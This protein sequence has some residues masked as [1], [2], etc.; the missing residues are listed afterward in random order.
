M[1]Y[2]I[3][4]QDFSWTQK[5][6]WMAPSGDLSTPVHFDTVTK[7]TAA[8]LN[9]VEG[10]D[11]CIQAGGN[12]GLWPCRYAKEF[13]Q[14]LT[15]EP[16][17]ENLHCL[18]HN[19]EHLGNVIVFGDAL[20]DVCGPVEVKHIERKPV[21]YGARYVEPSEH[22]D[23][24]QIRLDD[25]IIEGDVDFIHLDIE[26]RELF[27]LQGMEGTISNHEPVIALEHHTLDQMAVPVDAAAN[28]LLER[29]YEIAE[30]FKFEWVFKPI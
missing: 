7:E 19:V 17:A 3:H 10:H 1:S 9:Y 16:C 2:E 6:E 24:M 22:G 5:R 4:R 8:L 30:K 12:I 25:M 26:G 29:G 28:W 11:V 13:R 20:G 18:R 27:A 23:V 14:V 15:F 21:S